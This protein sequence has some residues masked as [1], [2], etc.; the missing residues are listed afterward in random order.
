MPRAKNA[1]PWREVASAP[2]WGRRPLGEGGRRITHAALEAILCDRDG[3]RLLPPDE[4]WRE[5]VVESFDLGLGA[6]STFERLGLRA[7]VLLLEWLP[8]VVIGKAARM[9]R[10]P[11]AT[12]IEYLGALERHRWALLTMLMV[13]TKIPMTVAAYEEGEPLRMTGFD[14]PTTASRRLRLAP[15]LEGRAPG[16]VA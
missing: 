5:R 13:A 6:C 14:R 3:E 16:G 11:L 8:I 1:R 2:D 12:R 7:L 4:V 10:L 9:S 15:P